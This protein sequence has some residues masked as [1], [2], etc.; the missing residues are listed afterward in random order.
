M[1]KTGV[2][3]LG[4]EV[5]NLTP[6]PGGMGT[7]LSM[8]SRGRKA[9]S[10]GLGGWGPVASQLCRGCHQLHVYHQG[11]QPTSYPAAQPRRDG[12][13]SVRPLHGQAWGPW[14]S[15]PLYSTPCYLHMGASGLNEH[16]LNRTD[17]GVNPACAPTGCCRHMCTH[18]YMDTHHFPTT[19]SGQFPSWDVPSSRKPSHP[20]PG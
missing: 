19:H 20:I 16:D 18:T 6:G 12:V 17:L 5:L 2:R 1:L 9:R 7:Y 8:V 15:L 13:S 4:S 11:L 14:A 10:L 3:E